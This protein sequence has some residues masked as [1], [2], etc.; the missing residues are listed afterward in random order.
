MSSP[1]PNRFQLTH[2]EQAAVGR[3]ARTPEVN[4][5]PAIEREPKGL[6]LRLTCRLAASPP[7]IV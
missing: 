1:K 3:K 7:N 4:P 6:F 5:Q 2:H